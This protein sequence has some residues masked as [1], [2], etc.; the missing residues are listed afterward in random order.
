[1]ATT[2]DIA[3]LDTPTFERD[4]SR[5]VLTPGQLVWRRF[6][7]HRM[8][9][10]GMIGFTLLLSF[11][12]IGSIFVGTDKANAVDLKARL[13]APNETYWM[14]TDS[15]GRDIFARIIHGGQISLIV[16]V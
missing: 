2:T 8:A 16:G 11:I 13:G 6:R 9:V 14:G 15:T 5:R 4:A 1:M 10:F 7:K 3:S 12:I